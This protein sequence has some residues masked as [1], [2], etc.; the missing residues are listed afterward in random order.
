MVRGNWRFP[1][2]AASSPS[3]ASLQGRERPSG[4]AAAR[5]GDAA[6]SWAG[7][8]A[9]SGIRGAAASWAGGATSLLGARPLPGGAGALSLPGAPEGS[10]ESRPKVPDA[11]AKRCRSEGPCLWAA[12]PRIP[13]QE[14][15]AAALPERLV[16]EAKA[17]TAPGTIYAPQ[18]CCENRPTPSA[19]D[20]ENARAR[21]NA[22]LAMVDAG[23]QATLEILTSRGI[24][25]S[26]K[27]R[28]RVLGCT[29][30]QTLHLWLT[31]AAVASS[32]AA[33]LRENPPSKAP[34]ETPRKSGDRSPAR[35]TKGAC[36]KRT[37][38]TKRLA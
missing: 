14:G 33:A 25:V 9:A 7:S 10:P 16:L 26:E 29:D 6:A 17:V 13:S 34:P 18:R 32:A 12:L 22:I 35:S 24:P 8:A 38:S 37:E 30:L 2:E 31:R 21:K 4:A 27:L 19:L 5:A 36:P 20:S 15:D 3:R 11:A 1:H 28:A 23:P